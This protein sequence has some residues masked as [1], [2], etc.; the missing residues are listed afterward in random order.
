M[1]FFVGL[2]EKRNVKRTN[3][4]LK[5]EKKNLA[6]I[7]NIEI[8]TNEMNSLKTTKIFAIE[9]KKVERGRE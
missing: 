6:R 8:V 9:P 2:A 3:A 5:D 7:R 1:E 4:K